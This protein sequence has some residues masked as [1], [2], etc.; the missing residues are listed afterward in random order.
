MDKGQR[1]VVD[2]DNNIR[3][4]LSQHGSQAAEKPEVESS[5]LPET[6]D[7][8]QGW[9]DDGQLLPTLAAK[10]ANA[11]GKTARIKTGNQVNRLAFGAAKAEGVHQKQ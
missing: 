11:G 9:S 10:A 3:S 1:V 7:P 6:G 8:A 5:F 2:A 4:L